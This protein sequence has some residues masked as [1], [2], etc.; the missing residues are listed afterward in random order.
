MLRW[1]AALSASLLASAAWAA[2]PPESERVFRERLLP[3]FRSPQPSSCVECHLAAVDLKDYLRP[4]ADETFLSLRDQGLVDAKAPKA[5]RLLAMIRMAPKSPNPLASKR[6]TEEADAFEAWIVA[7]AARADLVAAPPLDAAKRAGPARPPEVIRHARKS[8]LLERFQDLVWRDAERCAGC[9]RPP[10]NAKNEKQYGA[11][12]SWIRAADPEGTMDGLVSRGLLD[13]AAPEKSLLLRKPTEQEKHGG[14][15]KMLVGD[16]A[17]TRWSS[18]IRD[19]ARAKKDG[20][21]KAEDVPAPAEDVAL[22]TDCW[23]RLETPAALDGGAVGVEIFARE[24]DAWAKTP[25][26]TAS[27]HVEKGFQQTLYLH[28]RR[29]SDLERSLAAAGTLPKGRYL[30]R[31]YADDRYDPKKGK[32]PRFGDKQRVAEIEVDRE[33][34]AGYGAM[35]RLG[36]IGG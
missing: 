8:S 36:K 19:Y 12:V 7:S 17:W 31:A 35:N 14:G 27:R 5:S 23:V 34:P 30:V 9:H 16:E 26:A 6:R 29:G 13:L 28:A 32:P 20:Y 33:W 15:R 1:V 18:W 10:E 24:G 21:A 4:T 22:L 3:I 25:I 11:R 2:D